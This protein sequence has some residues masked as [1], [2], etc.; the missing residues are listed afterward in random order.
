M[1]KWHTYV[2]VGIVAY[3]IYAYLANTNGWTTNGV[4]FDGLGWLQTNL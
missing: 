3:E 4:P 1:K 2:L